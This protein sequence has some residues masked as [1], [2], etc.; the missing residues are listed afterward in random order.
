VARNLAD[1]ILAKTSHSKE[2][3]KEFP[4]IARRWNYR[5]VCLAALSA[6]LVAMGLSAA[7]PA[8]AGEFD[9]LDAAV[10]L[11]PTDAA[12]YSSMLR[13]GEMYKALVDSNA[14][15]KITAMPVV[16]TAVAK[17]KEEMGKSDGKAAQFQAAMANPEVHKV[18]DMAADMVSNE[19]FV[20]GDR[21]FVGFVELMQ[22]VYG[23]AYYGSIMNSFVSAASGQGPGAMN[24]QEVFGRA[25]ISALAQNADLLEFPNLV[26]GFKLKK[27]ELAKEQL[28]KLEMFANILLG[29]NAQVQEQL[30]DRFKK[31]KVGDH[32]YLVLELDGSMIP[33][34]QVPMDRLSENGIDPGEVQKVIDRVKT[35]KLVIALGVR[36]DYLLASIGSSLEALEKFG[37]SGDRL[38]DR[39]ELKPL[40]KHADQRL[41]SIDYLSES[42]ARQLGTQKKDVD[43]LQSLADGLLPAVPGLGDEQKDRIGKDVRSLVED[44]KSVIVEPGATVGFGFLTDRGIENYQYSW[45]VS[46][47][48]DGSKP[49]DLLQHVGGN[50]LF[51]AVARTKVDLKSY[52][53]LVKWLKVGYGYFNDFVLPMAPEN[54]REKVKQFLDKALPLVEQLDRANREMLFPALA[55]GQVALVV[56]GK[57]TSTRFHQALP[58]TEKPMP[59][60]EP[61]LVVGVSDAQL[62]KK[63]YREYRD[64]INGLIDAAR[65]IEG[66]EIPEAVRIPELQMSE[67]PDGNH[68]FLPMPEQWGFDKQ[69][70]PN[71][72]LSDKV[73]VLSLSHAHTDRLLKA[74]PPAAGG[75]LENV[76]RPLAG[77][78]WFDWAGLLGAADPWIFFAADQIMAD[79]KVPAEG[80]GPILDQVHTVLDVLK[81]LRAATDESY[82]EGDALVHHALLEIRDLP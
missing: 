21:R 76:D 1:A 75:V 10:K 73:V 8:A 22:K 44:L 42:L 61:A 54:D 13:G 59:M 69:I 60:I 63:A 12:F 14:Y 30:K 65:Q 35:M 11:V 46:A 64:V 15:K 29:M 17:L 39:A 2:S 66:V 4:M 48:L 36:E 20:Y 27:P 33:W 31:T 3:G 18:L 77:A 79:E 62:L 6:V 55:D 80:K 47:G 38:S 68:Y 19:V 45:G 28:V 52:D 9:R 25:L 57:L 51:A 81:T 32:E 70:A 74:T 23:S 82:V 41:V 53:L 71:F 16:Q 7:R 67:G 40:A 26:V 50:P 56:D 43:A 72:G 49:L 78:A 37:G 5:G 34:D 58:P 24:R